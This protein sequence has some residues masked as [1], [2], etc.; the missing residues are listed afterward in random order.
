MTELLGVAWM[1]L[2][3]TDYDGYF[4]LQTKQS[5]SE[6]DQA[7]LYW[8][9][10]SQGG[11]NSAFLRPASDNAKHQLWKLVPS[12]RNGYFYL[13]TLEAQGGVPNGPITHFGKSDDKLWKMVPA[14]EDYYY[15]Q[16]SQS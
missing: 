2:P 4:H 6:N 14:G 7:S 11:L 15:L 9:S 13:T 10:D 12:D 8:Q 1:A 16:T 3:F 5:A